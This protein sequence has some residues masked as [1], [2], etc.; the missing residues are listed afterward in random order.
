MENTTFKILFLFILSVTNTYA[1][2]Y[3]CYNYKGT[4]DKY[5]ITFSIQITEDFFGEKDKKDFNIN[6]VYKYDKHNNPIKLEGRIDFK[7]NKAY[8]YEIQ[9]NENTAVFEFN[10]STNECTGTWTKLST[11]EILPLHLNFVSK[12]DETSEEQAF[13]DVEILQSGSLPE[14]YF[15]GIYS[16]LTDDRAKMNTLKI[17]RKRDDSVFQILDFS[18]IKTP[19]GNVMTI[20]YDNVE[21]TD[22]QTRALTI[23]NKVGRMGGYLTVKYNPKTKKF[24]VNPKPTVEGAG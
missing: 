4:I 22:I 2:W 3:Q 16:K 21:S 5:P 11:K 12:L 20:I 15:V 1:G 13:E 14:F 19:T 6:G 8:I 7:S 18:K 17:L 10:F 9:N 24:K 23:S